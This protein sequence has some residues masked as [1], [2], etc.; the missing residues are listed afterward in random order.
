[1]SK[2]GTVHNVGRDHSVATF[3]VGPCLIYC[4]AIAIA[5]LL[6]FE[7][8]VEWFR[9]AEM[10]GTAILMAIL[11]AAVP[12]FNIYLSRGFEGALSDLAAIIPIAGLTVVEAAPK[13][14]RSRFGRRWRRSSRRVH[15]RSAGDSG[16]DGPTHVERIAQLVRV[17]DVRR[18]LLRFGAWH[19]FAR[20]TP[21]YGRAPRPLVIDI[22]FFR[23]PHP[24]LSAFA[25]YLSGT[26]IIAS[27]GYL[28]ITLAI[29][30]SPYGIR[31][32]L[33][34]WVGLL[35]FVRCCRSDGL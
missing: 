11:L 19:I 12:V 29:A 27:F 3:D 1:M 16:R 20:S 33:A 2:P 10:H 25:R 24:A 9:D 8:G 15:D 18:A 34:V 4:G 6:V 14:K 31:G 28:L 23:L 26:G 5:V 22:P 17:R 21:R 35:A 13:S 32:P 30:L 7:I